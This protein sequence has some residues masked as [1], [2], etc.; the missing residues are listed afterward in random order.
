MCDSTQNIML[1]L[2]SRQQSDEVI[3]TIYKRINVCNYLTIKFQIVLV[4]LFLPLPQIGQRLKDIG[5]GLLHLSTCKDELYHIARRGTML[6]A[7]LRSLSLVQKE[8]HFTLPMFLK[9]FDQAIGGEFPEEYT[10][11]METT[12]VN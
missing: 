11:S 2:V 10:G 5:A 9:L 12:T 8:Y 7:L 3:L 1:V 4:F 6:F